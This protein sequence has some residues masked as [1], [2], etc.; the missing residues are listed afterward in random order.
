M[1]PIGC[2]SSRAWQDSAIGALEDVAL[3]HDEQ[4]TLDVLLEH[5]AVPEIAVRAAAE[6]DRGLE[7][8]T[9][10]RPIPGLPTWSRRP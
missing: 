1:G 3:A 2:L 9:G 8:R 6:R 7:G 10:A 4:A 5:I